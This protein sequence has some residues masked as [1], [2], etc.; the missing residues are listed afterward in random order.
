[1]TFVGTCRDMKR[2]NFATIQRR[3]SSGICLAPG[4]EIVFRSS[5][6]NIRREAPAME[7]RRCTIKSI[8]AIPKPGEPAPSETSQ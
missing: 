8:E 7:E 5:H 6:P 4:D 3:V 2:A 1:V